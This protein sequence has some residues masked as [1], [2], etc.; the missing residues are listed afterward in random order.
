MVLLP[1]CVCCGADPCFCP[2]PPYI[3]VELEVDSESDEYSALMNYAQVQRTVSYPPPTFAPVYT[4]SL[5]DSRVTNYSASVGKVAKTTFRL[6]PIGPTFTSRGYQF[7]YVAADGRRLDGY[8]R[9]EHPG[10]GGS[11]GGLTFQLHISWVRD[12]ASG[13]NLTGFTGSSV[14]YEFYA[15]VLYI[16]C[17]R[18]PSPVGV[19]RSQVCFI[20]VGPERFS[21]GGVFPGHVGRFR[22][23]RTLSDLT[24]ISDD[25]IYETV[26]AVFPCKQSMKLGVTFP[27]SYV[28]EKF[29]VEPNFVYV[30]FRHEVSI[31]NNTLPFSSSI[32][33]GTYNPPTVPTDRH[34][35]E[36]SC[37]IHSVKFGADD[38]I[39]TNDY[40]SMRSLLWYSP[41]GMR[42]EVVSA[43]S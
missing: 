26:G 12:T 13:T 31:S 22:F 18:P 5:I 34:A 21:G 16:A 23:P 4:E 39:R 14:N 24:V 17:Y 43:Y 41:G 38:L 36:F 35:F 1:G 37:T 2:L 19:A 9:D 32:S 11:C 7:S 40:G 27:T 8:L 33:T 20:P 3:D 28:I 15:Q 42:A 29:P 30:Y 25:R 10:P 6:L